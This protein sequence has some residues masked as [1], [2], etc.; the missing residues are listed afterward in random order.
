VQFDAVTQVTARRLAET[1]VEVFLVAETDDA[2]AN[3][4]API[5]NVTSG[6]T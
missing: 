6:L 3:R 4:P 2:L 1:I 5:T